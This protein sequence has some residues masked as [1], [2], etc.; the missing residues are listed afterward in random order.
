MAA[1]EL[2]FARARTFHPSTV[3]KDALAACPNPSSH[4]WDRTHPC[5]VLVHCRH[6]VR[7]LF[8]PGL[9]GDAVTERPTHMAILAQ[10][11]R[12]RPIVME[13]APDAFT[14][15]ALSTDWSLLEA[16]S[17]PDDS[18]ADY[19][20]RSTL[21]KNL[22]AQRLMLTIGERGGYRDHG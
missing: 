20:R 21:V 14:L 11:A 18:A 8:E 9:S 10:P 7:P 12:R 3:E 16:R 4:S 2:A 6:D 22:A 13:L 17:T 19:A 15:L 1:I 5:V